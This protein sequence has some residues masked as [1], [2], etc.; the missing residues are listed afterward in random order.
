MV[1]SL[2]DRNSLLDIINKTSK[3][4]YIPL[5]VSGGLRSIDDMKKAFA[6]GADKICINT[7][8]VKNPS[9]INKAANIFGSS[10]IVVAIENSLTNLKA[11][12]WFI[13]IM[14]EK[15]QIKKQ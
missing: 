11:K 6:A 12:I 7:A 10:N 5:T 9:I 4:I 14:A 2:Y 1:A 15:L 8:A 3:N 13:Q